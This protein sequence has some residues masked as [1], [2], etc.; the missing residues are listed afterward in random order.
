MSSYSR[1]A[2][3]YSKINSLNSISR[4]LSWDTSTMMPEGSTKYRAEDIAVL[5]RIANKMLSSKKLGELLEEVSESE[6]NQWEKANINLIKH[7]RDSVLAVD[8]DLNEK[9]TKASIDCEHK[10][11]VARKNNSFKSILSDF[12]NLVDMVK[13]VAKARSDYFGVGQ[14]D[15]LLD[16]YDRGRKEAEIDPIVASMK[17]FLPEFVQKVLDK[18][19]SWKIHRITKDKFP[20]EKQRELG[21]NC[22]NAIGFDFT[23]GRLDV[24]THPFCGGGTQDVRITTRY[25]H[26]EFLSSLM[27]VMHETGHALYQQNLPEAYCNQAVGGPLGMSIH[28]SQSLLVEIQVARSK[29]FLEF[30]LPKTKSIFDVSGK[31]YSAENLYYIA[32]EV[33]PSFI[34]VESD[35]VTYLAHVILRY[36]LEKDI[37]SGNLKIKDLPAAWNAKMKDYLGIKPKTDTDGCMQDIH[38]FSGMFGYFPNYMLGTMHASQFFTTM[39]NDIKDLPKNI[40]K[41]NFRP[42]T[43]WLKKN[44]HS[45][46]SLYSS[47]ELLKKV[48]GKELDVE[49]YKQY[50]TKKFL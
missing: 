15:A 16:I 39:S 31:A 49:G 28:E 43:E 24:S 19:K 50:L 46:G 10:W 7:Y 44:I 34:R 35:E 29:E 4:V 40:Q 18:Q 8:P 32:N 45:Q 21:I 27:A 20:V 23:R 33:K 9:L 48:T 38:W 25:N 2:E 5:E 13:E 17:T 3:V 11:R 26:D 42:M 12:S 37:L 1:V 6:C 47:N 41:G 22:M 30:V 14:Y 36:E